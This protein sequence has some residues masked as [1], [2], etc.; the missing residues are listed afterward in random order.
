MDLPRHHTIREGD[1]RI[2]NPLAPG[3]LATLGR[4]IK[5]QP[6]WTLADFCSG[7]GEM[8]CTWARDHGITGHGVEISTVNIGLARQRAA[9]LGVDV[10]FAHGDAAEFVADQPVDVASCIGATWIGNGVAGTI[11]ILERSLKP[12]G[13]L[14][15]GEPYWRLDPPDE[16]TAQACGVGSR[17]EFLSLP[18]L[19]GQFG[20]LGWDLVEMVLSS[21]DDWDR[22]SASHWLSTR[23]WLDANP[24]DELAPQMRAELDAEP[25]RYVQY[26]REFLGWGVFVL[27]KRKVTS[28]A[29]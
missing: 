8:L 5:L 2:L 22:Y 21:P 15:I 24:D 6:G 13:M 26:R 16:Q 25:A 12:G 28:L 11:R 29:G 23:R 3:K 14:L 20:E 19:V 1:L 18:E 9:D 17:D 27:L 7:R 10:T 4:V